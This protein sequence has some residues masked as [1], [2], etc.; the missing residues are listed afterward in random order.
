[1]DRLP[2]LA[3]EPRAA[4]RAA[5][6]TRSAGR[7]SRPCSSPARPTGSAH[8]K[9]DR[10]RAQRAE[11]ATGP[12]AGASPLPKAPSRPRVSGRQPQSSSR[13][14]SRTPARGAGADAAPSTPVGKG[15]HGQRRPRRRSEKRRRERSA[16]AAKPRSPRPLTPGRRASSPGAY[17]PA[18][19]DR[20]LRLAAPGQ[21]RLVGDGPRL[22]RAQAHLPAVVVDGRNSKGRVSI[23]CR[24]G[25]TSQAHSEVL[26][27]RM[28]RSAIA[29]RSSA[30]R[31]SRRA[32]N[33]ERSP[34]SYDEAS[35]RGCRRSR[36]RTSRAAFRRA[37]CS[38]RWSSS[39]SRR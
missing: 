14:R 30:C 25:T 16:G 24:S 4:A 21:A 36:T 18:G 27:Q 10:E 17:R 26:C 7:S 8:A 37:R 22:S 6:A 1:M 28:Q 29:A 11:A 15:A 39:C 13:H 20:R 3:D 19:P 12:P 2:W 34:P 31:G 33:G 9:L 38:P 35:C 23:G 32:S 5:R